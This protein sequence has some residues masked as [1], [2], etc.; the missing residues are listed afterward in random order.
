MPYGQP[1]DGRK[2]R[3][4]AYRGGFRRAYHTRAGPATGR[5]FQPRGAARGFQRNSGYY[6]R[7]GVPARQYGGTEL[8]FFEGDLDVPFISGLGTVVPTLNDIPQGTGERERIGRK[9]T[10]KKISLRFGVTLL[11]ALDQTGPHPG[12]LVRCMVVLDK[13]C[14]GTLIG[15]GSVLE[16]LDYLSFNRLDQKDRYHILWDK[17]FAINTLSMVQTSADPS[18]GTRIAIAEVRRYIE[19]NK[20]INIPIEFSSTTGV[21][22]EIR[23]NNL[24]IIWIASSGSVAVDG[25]VRIRFEG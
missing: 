11:Q 6:G 18:P 21:L 12:T 10:L 25:K 13:Q 15:A 1:Y 17:R 5:R 16:T 2:R 22:S 9:C 20:R 3:R 23:S 7:Y 19:F 24:A 4:T 8:K 14:N